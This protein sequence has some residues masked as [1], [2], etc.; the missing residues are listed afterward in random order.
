MLC[1]P[2]ALSAQEVWFFPRKGGPIQ[3]T[4]KLSLASDTITWDGGMV[5]LNSLQ[6]IR[7]PIQGEKV[8]LKSRRLPVPVRSPLLLPGDQSLP[9]R[10]QA[11]FRIPAPNTLILNPAFSKDGKPSGR[12]PRLFVSRKGIL[13]RNPATPEEPAKPFG[14]LARQIRRGGAPDTLDVHLFVDRSTGTMILR[15]N[16][17]PREPIRF[18]PDTNPAAFA[19][20]GAISPVQDE[21]LEDVVL[22]GWTHNNDPGADLDPGPGQQKIWLQNGDVLTGTLERMA[23]GQVHFRLTSARTVILPTSRILEIH[24]HLAEPGLPESK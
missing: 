1:I 16:H 6:L 17:L 4:G 9:S 13:V 2:L 11:R 21:L 12:T 3:V 20:V 22:S 23:D 14:D 8:F 7:F 5:S 10:Y 15:T 24:F 18:P 19:H